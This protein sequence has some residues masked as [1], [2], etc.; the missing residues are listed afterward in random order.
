MK[1]E[2]QRTCPSCGNELSG[3]MESC[4]VCMLR[5]AL[6]G[7]V[8]SGE[9]SASEEAVR[10]TPDQPA[11]RFEHY[12]LVTDGDGEPVELGRGAMGVLLLSVLKQHQLPISNISGT[13]SPP[14]GP[15][16]CPESERQ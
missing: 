4:P 15:T 3:P 9:S 1:T 6:V 16:R 13:I 8:G 5:Q 2:S 14:I 11:Q 10:P 12:E 7:G